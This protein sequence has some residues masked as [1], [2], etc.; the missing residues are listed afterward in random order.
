[1]TMASKL[2]HSQKAP[3]QTV[4]ILCGKLIEVSFSQNAKAY[5]PIEVIKKYIQ[6]QGEKL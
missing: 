2:E 1:M 4:L 5:S 3:S 6:S